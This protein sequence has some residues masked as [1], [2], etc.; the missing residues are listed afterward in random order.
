MSFIANYT[1]V[2][3]VQQAKPSSQSC[4]VLEVL[5]VVLPILNF[6]G[7][8]CTRGL[9]RFFKT[10]LENEALRYMEG[11]NRY[12]SHKLNKSIPTD[13]QNFDNEML[14]STYL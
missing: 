6:Y 14:K 2:F 3:N 7:L 8:Q 13:V 11:L 10:S 1:S 12:I 4:Y 5:P 9:G